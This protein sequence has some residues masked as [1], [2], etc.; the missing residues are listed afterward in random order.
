MGELGFDLRFL[1]SDHGSF[2]KNLNYPS[3]SGAQV[4]SFLPHPSLPQAHSVNPGAWANHLSKGSVISR[5]Q[6]LGPDEWSWISS[7]PG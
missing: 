7:Q 2:S 4:L 6:V 3:L 5:F 1:I